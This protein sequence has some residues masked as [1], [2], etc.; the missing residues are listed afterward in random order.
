MLLLPLLLGGGRRRRRRHRAPLGQRLGDERVG[1]A[2]EKPA[3]GDEGVGDATGGEGGGALRVVELEGRV[4]VGPVLEEA[5]DVGV[6]LG[7]VAVEVVGDDEGALVLWGG[8]VLV[9]VGGLFGCGCV[10]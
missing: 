10:G 8:V 3:G 5:P 9:L 1:G 2:R 4:G 7:V 6:A